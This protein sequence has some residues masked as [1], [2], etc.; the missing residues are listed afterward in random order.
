MENQRGGGEKKSNMNISFCGKKG[1][2]F[3]YHMLPLLWV[4]SFNEYLGLNKGK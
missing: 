1:F 4:S 3:S 2:Y